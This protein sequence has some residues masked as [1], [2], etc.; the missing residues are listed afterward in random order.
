MRGSA[1]PTPQ[2]AL[3]HSLMFLSISFP[4]AERTEAGRNRDGAARE[5]HTA[6]SNGAS[7][8]AGVEN[9]RELF[10]PKNISIHNNNN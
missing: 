1:T 4:S 6:V 8:A 10:R 7:T 3:F 2:K 5:Q 9:G